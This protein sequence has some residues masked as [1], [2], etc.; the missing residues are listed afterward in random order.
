MAYRYYFR[1]KCFVPYVVNTNSA[2]QVEITEDA[3]VEST[4]RPSNAP[5]EN[6]ID[7][8]AA[9]SESEAV[10]VTHLTHTMSTLFLRC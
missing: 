1:C 7:Y 9:L 5:T 6:P 3:G 8:K 2:R 4:Q 10:T